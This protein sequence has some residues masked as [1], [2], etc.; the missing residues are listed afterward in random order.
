LIDT[1]TFEQ[2]LEEIGA[3][4]GE[5]LGSVLPTP[6]GPEAQLAEAM[7]YATL[8]GGKRIRPFLLVASADMFGVSRRSSLRAAAALELIHTYSLIHDDLPCMDDDDLR[9]GRPAVHIQFD[10]ATAILAGDALQALGFEVLSDEETHSNPEVRLALV[11]ALAY[12]AG[13]RGMAGGQMIDLAAENETL[14]IPEV[15]RLQQLKTGAL[16]AFAC[17]AGAVLGRAPDRQRQYLHA[18]AHDLGLAF[19]IADDLLDAEGKESVAGKRLRKDGVAGKA[20]YVSLMG[21]DGA[22]R[23]AELLADQAVGHLKSFAEKGDVLRATA[24]FAI[25]RVS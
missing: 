4:V 24:N 15:T 23:Q 8:P 7:R 16:I 25:N 19:Q 2:A 6:G 1:E 9:R 20:T 3:A 14:A 17:E 5:V 13:S 10:E 21:I 11:G 18:Y 12:A 22:R